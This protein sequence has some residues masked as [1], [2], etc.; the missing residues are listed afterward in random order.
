MDSGTDRPSLACLGRGKGGGDHS[1]H[2]GHEHKRQPQANSLTQN[3]WLDTG[4]AEEAR[5]LGGVSR[6]RYHYLSCFLGRV[7][8]QNLGLAAGEERGLEV[9]AGGKQEKEY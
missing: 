2:R 5:R 4:E 7:L 6:L 9:Q 1:V 8:L 3:I